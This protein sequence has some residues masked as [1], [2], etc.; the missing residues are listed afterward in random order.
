MIFKLKHIGIRIL[1]QSI[2]T[3]LLIGLLTLIMIYSS[4]RKEDTLKALNLIEHISSNLSVAGNHIDLAINLQKSDVSFVSNSSTTFI[5]ERSAETS[6]LI[7]SIDK[8]EK[9]KYLQNDLKENG[10]ADSLK[11]SLRKYNSALE[12]II[13][14]LQEKGN[15]TGGVT[16]KLKSVA[17]KLNKELLITPESELRG[18]KLKCIAEAYLSGFASY[19]LQQLK[20]FTEEIH[21]TAS[22]KEEFDASTLIE[23]S[24]ELLNYI[25]KIIKI[26]NRLSNIKKGTGQIASARKIYDVAKSN[27]NQLETSISDLSRQYNKRWT[28]YLFIAALI[29]VL[30]Y[31]IF[32]SKLYVKIKEGLVNT[33]S[34]SAKIMK[35]DLISTTITATS[36]EF[37]QISHN[38][39]NI[40]THLNKRKDVIGDMLNNNFDEDIEILGDQDELGKNLVALRKKIQD[41][42]TEQESQIREGKIRQYINEGLAKFSDIMRNYSDDTEA[43]TLILVKELIKYLG[44]IQGA[45][46]IA[47]EEDEDTLNLMAAFAYDRRKYLKKTFKKGEGIVGTCAVEKKTINITEIPTDY[48]QIK[49]GLGDAPPNNILIVPVMHDHDL[50]GVIEI[51]SLKIL[52]E[53]EVELAEHVAS[54][55]ATTILT[56]RNNAR[57]GQ[58]LKKSQEQAAEMAEQEEEMRQNMEELKATQEESSRR[59]EEMRGIID[60]IETSFYVVEYNLEGGIIHA[61]EKMLLFLDQTS[62]AIEGKQHHEVFSSESNINRT[63]INEIVENKK[64][65]VVTEILAWGSRNLTYRHTLSPVISKQGEVIKIINLVLI[66]E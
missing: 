33:S 38:I 43:L 8:L 52:V 47:D 53:H 7:T 39:E 17:L 62:E 37:E 46:F 35:G 32:L 29:S 58:L 64:T 3:I 15:Q 12:Q 40:R 30:I 25:D 59:E 36:F 65:K 6:E 20:Q 14:T 4:K 61:N 23:Y 66:E 13:L 63:L 48:I 44:A 10:F 28:L 9:I 42:L 16:A 34:L 11:S 2:L 26:D 45:L 24:S 21:E 27:L 41:N 55:L 18:I 50:I 49:S 60:A 22:F 56:V 19:Q 57:T 51:A 31:L 54:N 1:L 5:Q